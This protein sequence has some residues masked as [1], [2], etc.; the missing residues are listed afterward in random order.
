MTWVRR[1][2]SVIAIA[3]VAAVL[4]SIAACSGGDGGGGDGDDDDC[5][6]DASGEGQ[7]FNAPTDAEVIQKVPT[8]PPLED[9]GL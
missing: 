5:V 1:S 2:V 3:A 4:G 7:L 6:P 9:E 8:H